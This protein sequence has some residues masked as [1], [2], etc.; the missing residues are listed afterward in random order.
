MNYTT[1]EERSVFLGKYIVNNKET[2]RGAAKAF[3]IS[4]STVHIDVT[5][6][7]KKINPLLWKQVRNVLD[8]NKA[9]RH[10]RGGQ[11]TKHKYETLKEIENHI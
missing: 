3:G 7:L 11:A 6:R 5:Q 10:I 2:V 9:E 4:K 8:E 1:I